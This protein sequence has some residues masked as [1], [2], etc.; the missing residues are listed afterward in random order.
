MWLL[1]PSP[2]V[3]SFLSPGL[4]REQEPPWPGHP[5]AE[6]PGAAQE[7]VPEQFTAQEPRAIIVNNEQTT[8]E[9]VNSSQTFWEQKM[10]LNSL[11]KLIAMDYSLSFNLPAEGGLCK[12]QSCSTAFIRKGLCL[13]NRGEERLGGNLLG[14]GSEFTCNV[15]LHSFPCPLGGAVLS[16]HFICE[17]LQGGEVAFPKSLA[18]SRL[19]LWDFA[20]PG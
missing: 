8:A 12:W 10:R 7:I 11:N 2:T 13:L 9:M 3:P 14:C 15:H 20:V 19:E 6:S 16:P 18:E 1:H 17:V 4:R 5:I